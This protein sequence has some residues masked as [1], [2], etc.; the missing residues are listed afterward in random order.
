MSHS[1]T[2]NVKSKGLNES[3]P[4]WWLEFRA[5]KSKWFGKTEEAIERTVLILKHNS[6]KIRFNEVRFL[7]K[8][9]AYQEAREYLEVINS[10]IKDQAEI[11]ILLAKC[12]LGMGNFAEAK[13]VIEEALEIE[14]E[15]AEYWDLMA[16]CQLEQ[17]DWRAA[18][19]ALD[20]SMR[21]APKEAETIFRL[22]IIYAY[23]GETLE[24]LRCFQGCCQ[25]R[26]RHGPYWEM[27]AETHLQLE[28]I[29]QASRSYEKA[30]RF[31]INP[32]LA[33]RLAYCYI[34]LD[35]IKK[36]IKYYELVLRH[37]PDHYDA[38]CNLSAVYQNQGR[39]I[40]ALNLLE[41]AHNIYPNDAVLLNNLAYTLVHLGRTRRAIETYNSA[42]K[43]AP[44]NL[45]IIYNLSVC[46]VR[47]GNWEEGIEIL[48]KL[49]EINP[50]HSDGWALLG[51]IYDQI[52]QYDVAIDCFNKSMN[53][54]S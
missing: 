8:V 23:H 14:P 19:L 5:F 52:A 29:P 47:K 33:A 40:E 11:K 35:K 18:I 39:S 21:A 7:L 15:K 44:D 32:E 50:Q 43:L 3:Y 36:G 20:N 45:L 30:L 42:L 10:E 54:A 37:E 12:Y 16:D 22:G 31:G 25:L 49:L 41:R 34:H 13:E 28:Q 6:S 26:P 46:L 48:T 9:Q 24:A 4:S 51:N 17:G 1:L 38:L 2:S 27:K 53:L